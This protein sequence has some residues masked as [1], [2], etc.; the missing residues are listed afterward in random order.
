MLKEKWVMWK[1]PKT[2][3]GTDNSESWGKQLSAEGLNLKTL[4]KHLNKWKD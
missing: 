2:E 3:K 4:V 1:A